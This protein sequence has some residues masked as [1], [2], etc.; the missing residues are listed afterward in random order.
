NNI[1]I[2]GRG[3]TG[4]TGAFGASGA[5]GVNGVGRDSDLAGYDAGNT[6]GTPCSGTRIHPNGGARMCGTAN[7]GG[8]DG[9]GNRV[10]PKTDFT[11]FSGIVGATGG[12]GDPLLGGNA[13]TGGDAGSDMRLDDNGLTCYIGSTMGWHDYGFDGTSGK[14]GL[15]G[16]KVDG[17]T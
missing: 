3:G 1:V 9:G 7:V 17:C 11:Q 8:G 13:G 10:P 5:F 16:P 15:H 4:A 2:A 6:N 14:D 12:A